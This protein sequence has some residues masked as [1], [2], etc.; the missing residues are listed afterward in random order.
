MDIV[1][2]SFAVS[3]MSVCALALAACSS[4][5]HLYHSSVDRPTTIAVYDPIEDKPLWLKKIPV[6][7][8]LEIDL[9]HEGD[10]DGSKVD[11]RP[12]TSLAWRMYARG[13]ESGRP[14]SPKKHAQ[15]MNR[16][17]KSHGSE[18]ASDTDAAGSGEY[19]GLE[20]LPGTPVV[21]KVTYRPSPEY[22]SND[23]PDFPVH[24]QEVSSATSTEV[25]M[26]KPE[27]ASTAEPTAPLPPLELD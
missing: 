23:E 7:Y 6:G 10:R 5:K 4:D 1:R 17:G 20:D 9:D 16:T 25:P 13:E 26:P 18:Y 3:L 27:P 22:P 12:A 19:F 24:D 11:P 21:I 15:R 8:S 14:N 2:S